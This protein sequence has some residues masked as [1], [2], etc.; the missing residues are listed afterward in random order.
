MFYR[1]F[2]WW[3]YSSPI[4][5]SSESPGTLFWDLCAQTMC[6]CDRSFHT[7]DIY[8]PA[9]V[10][11]HSQG[12]SRVLIPSQHS[13]SLTQSYRRALNNHVTRT[14]RPYPQIE[15]FSFSSFSCRKLTVIQLPPCRKPD[16]KSTALE[17]APQAFGH[18]VYHGGRLRL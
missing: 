2:K 10:E 12:I 16:P 9:Q 11:T 4:T 1:V 17:R 5:G 13:L 14:Y 3:S 18:V 15:R 7:P 8:L 6:M